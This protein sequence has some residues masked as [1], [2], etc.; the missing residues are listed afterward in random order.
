LKTSIQNR[1][2]NFKF[3]TTSLAVGLTV[4]ERL[5]PPGVA[6]VV[7]LVTFLAPPITGEAVEVTGFLAA[8]VV[9][10]MLMAE[11]LVERRL[12]LVVLLSCQP[13]WWLLDS[14]LQLLGNER[15]LLKVFSIAEVQLVLQLER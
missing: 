8:A 9:A 2:F 12:F 5:A 6:R 13:F 15:Y 1:T 3:F 14:W 4:L 11:M 7:V 10:A